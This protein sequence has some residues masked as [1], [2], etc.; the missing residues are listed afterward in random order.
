MCMCMYMYVYMYMYMYIKY[1]ILLLFFLLYKIWDI[2]IFL[3]YLQ[4][5]NK[6]M[7]RVPG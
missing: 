6:F 4:A 2:I 1:G 5:Y 3:N 7:T